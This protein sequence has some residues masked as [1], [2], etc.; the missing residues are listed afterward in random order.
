VIS[1]TSLIA[2]AFH[3]FGN[4]VVC[5]QV[6]HKYDTLYNETQNCIMVNNACLVIDELLKTRNI[7]WHSVQCIP[8]HIRLNQHSVITS[9]QQVLQMCKY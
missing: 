6:H 1:V 8:P 3:T 9:Q 7:R 2:H 5:D 4:Y